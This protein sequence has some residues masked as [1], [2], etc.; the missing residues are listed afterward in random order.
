[1]PV[2]LLDM[3]IKNLSPRLY[4]L[5]VQSHDLYFIPAPNTTLIT[6]PLQLTSQNLHSPTPYHPS[7]GIG[8]RRTRF[9]IKPPHAPR[10]RKGSSDR[11]HP[12]C[13]DP[14]SP[15]QSISQ[16]FPCGSKSNWNREDDQQPAAG[17]AIA[18]INNGEV[19]RTARTLGFTATDFD[20]DLC[21]LVS[22]A[23]QT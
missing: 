12:T 2:D 19:S 6:S 14:P 21:V 3:F 7:L 11:L 17:I 15:A 13:A 23:H 4:R 10:R 20:A 16:I 22:A 18:Y 9:S 1:M 8:L 5:A